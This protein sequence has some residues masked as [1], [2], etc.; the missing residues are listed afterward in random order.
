MSQSSQIQATQNEQNVITQ[1]LEVNSIEKRMKSF[2][3]MISTGLNN[4]NSLKAQSKEWPN[5]IC[6]ENFKNLRIGISV[7]L[8]VFSLFFLLFTFLKDFDI[9]FHVFNFIWNN[10]QIENPTTTPFRI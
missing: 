2:K 6:K 4:L 7:V 9:I 10:F 8:L 3:N 5:L 1:Q